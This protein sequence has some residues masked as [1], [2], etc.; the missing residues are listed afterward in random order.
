MEGVF[1]AGDTAVVLD[2]LITTGETKFETIEKLQAAGL[3]VRDV[4]VLIHREQGATAALAGRGFR[5]HA[6]VT[7]RELMD[8]WREQGAISAGQYQAVL[9]YLSRGH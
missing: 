7:V 4:V 3:Q 6:V 8:T 2:D 1:R 9:D 5:L